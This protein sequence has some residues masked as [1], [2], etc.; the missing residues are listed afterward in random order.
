MPNDST[1]KPKSHP[2]AFKIGVFLN[3][4]SLQGDNLHASHRRTTTDKIDEKTA[5]AIAERAYK[6]VTYWF[7][8]ADE[9]GE[10]GRA[11]ERPAE[12]IITTIAETLIDDERPSGG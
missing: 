6:L 7:E 3:L 4:V 12:N 10:W 5:R 9:S 11:F 2:D 8:F 1:E